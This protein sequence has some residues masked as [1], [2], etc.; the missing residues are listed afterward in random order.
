MVQGFLFPCQNIY[1]F[2]SYADWIFLTLWMKINNE[3]K[4]RINITGLS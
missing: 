3:K 4:Y 1:F 2:I